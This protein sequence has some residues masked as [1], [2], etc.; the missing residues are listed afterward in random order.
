MW[1]EEEEEGKEVKEEES[2]SEEED[3]ES[4]S[5]MLTSVSV[6]EQIEVTQAT[7]GVTA[8]GTK[9]GEEDRFFI[10]GW[11]TSIWEEYWNFRPSKAQNTAYSDGETINEKFNKSETHK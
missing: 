3:F 2:V 8:T 4:E 10:V 9:S 6:V 11:K 7:Q 1:N 5:E